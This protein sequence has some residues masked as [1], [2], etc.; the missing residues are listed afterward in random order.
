MPPPCVCVVDCS[1]D[2]GQ[3]EA[4][5]EEHIDGEGFSER[6]REELEMWVQR[7]SVDYELNYGLR[8]VGG[9]GWVEGWV[10]LHSLEPCLLI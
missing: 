3:M 8:W 5:L 10:W 6:C 9:R 1:T 7:H 4:C 2:D